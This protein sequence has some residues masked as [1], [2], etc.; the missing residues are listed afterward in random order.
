[1][2]RKQ[3]EITEGKEID[4]LLKQ[5]TVGRL[6]T[7][8]R[9]GYPYITPVNYIFLNGK[10]YFHCAGSGEKL[11]NIRQDPQVCFEVDIPLA[12]LDSGFFQ[13]E[14]PCGVTQFFECVIIRGRAEQVMDLQE[15]VE[16][17]NSLMAVHEKV[18]GF[19]GVRAEMK[20]VAA[21]T[22]MAIRIDSISGKSNLAQYKTK[23][24]RQRITDY[25]TQRGWLGDRE[26]VERIRAWSN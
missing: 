11:D 25:L 13:E 1:M 7:I 21:C 6:A 20:G 3:N 4:A 15:K 23:N 19:S 18:E 26:T 12:Y 16:A 17:L 8:G 24:E 2:R 14:N 10:I 22:V 9:D 5:C